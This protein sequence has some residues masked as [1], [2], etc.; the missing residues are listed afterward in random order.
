MSVSH[1]LN[2]L[3]IT[4]IVVVQANMFIF[5]SHFSFRCSFFFFFLFCLSICVSSF[6]MIFV[7]SL[8]STIYRLSFQKKKIDLH[9]RN[10]LP[11][12]RNQRENV[13]SWFFVRRCLC[14][15]QPVYFHLTILN[16]YHSLV[17]IR[18]Y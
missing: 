17:S 6:Q 13:R 8:N 3:L 15:V 2:S 5:V 1:S 14:L 12:Q 7:L 16:H 18:V 4:N 10:M 11:G 9:Y